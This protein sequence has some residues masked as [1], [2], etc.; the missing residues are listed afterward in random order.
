[1]GWHNKHMGKY[2]F[3]DTYLTNPCRDAIYN[4]LRMYILVL[5]CN[6]RQTIDDWLRVEGKLRELGFIPL[7]K[8]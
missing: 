2:K 7:G 8:V 3:T 6:D 1:M 5:V 4:I